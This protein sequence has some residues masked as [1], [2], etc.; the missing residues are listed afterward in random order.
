MNDFKK[1]KRTKSLIKVKNDQSLRIRILIAMLKKNSEVCKMVIE[2]QWKVTCI[3][4]EWDTHLAQEKSK[5][6]LINT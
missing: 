6:S 4:L 3:I 5:Y 2:Y 1:S